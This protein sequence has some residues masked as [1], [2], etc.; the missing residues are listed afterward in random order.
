MGTMHRGLN[1][2]QVSLKEENYLIDEHSSG[3]E[4]TELQKFIKM[5]VSLNLLEILGSNKF[6]P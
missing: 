6:S 2:L 4:H 5:Q 3:S 1:L